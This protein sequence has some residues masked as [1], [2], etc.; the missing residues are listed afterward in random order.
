MPSSDL[1][2]KFMNRPSVASQKPKLPNIDLTKL[3]D[4]RVTDDYVLT[5][6]NEDTLRIGET[7]RTNLPFLNR[8]K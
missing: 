8:S 2:C 5:S 4:K 3:N 1:K 7:K 6:Q